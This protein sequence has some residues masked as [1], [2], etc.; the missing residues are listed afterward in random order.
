MSSQRCLFYNS[1]IHRSC[2]LVACNIFGT[3]N[4]LFY[5]WPYFVLGLLLPKVNNQ[6]LFEMIWGISKYKYE[7]ARYFTLFVCIYNMSECAALSDFGRKSWNG[8]LLSNGYLQLFVLH[9][10]IFLLFYINRIEI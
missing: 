5:Y 9:F 8:I 6:Y 10:L 1:N 2:F 3:D 4:R 7:K